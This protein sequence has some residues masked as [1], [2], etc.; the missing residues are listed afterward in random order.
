MRSLPFAVVVLAI[1]TIAASAYGPGNFCNPPRPH[2]YENSKFSGGSSNITAGS[3][4]LTRAGA[5]VP[6]FV[7]TIDIYSTPTGSTSVWPLITQQS[8]AAGIAQVGQDTRWHWWPVLFYEIE[9]C[10]GYVNGPIEINVGAPCCGSAH[11]VEVDHSGGTGNVTLWVDGTPVVSN[12]HVDWIGDQ[13]QI[14]TETHSE[15]DTNYGG[16]QYP[17][18]VHNTTEC[19]VPANQSQTCFTPSL[20]QFT[21]SAT[22][23][24]MLIQFDHFNQSFIT[25]DR[26]CTG[27]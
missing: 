27:P 15:Y 7:P 26:D 16:T 8:C 4:W 5:S 20:N 18:S 23:P 14:S 9:P 6:Y 24:W 10:A 25:W 2:T 21:G 11:Y 19:Y 3:G 12:R 13:L 17:S 1:C 22:V